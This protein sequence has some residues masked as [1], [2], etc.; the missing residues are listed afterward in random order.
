MFLW[1]GAVV[2]LGNLLSALAPSAPLILV[3]RWVALRFSPLVSRPTSKAL[4]FLLPPP[5]L[6]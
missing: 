6:V 4:L 2:L 5:D 3:R 1:F